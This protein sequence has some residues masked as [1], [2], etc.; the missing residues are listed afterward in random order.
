MAKWVGIVS[1]GDGMESQLLTLNQQCEGHHLCEV[2]GDV[3]DYSPSGTGV[4][5]AGRHQENDGS[6]TG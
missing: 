3:D 6:Q 2:A 5:R 4:L 1:I